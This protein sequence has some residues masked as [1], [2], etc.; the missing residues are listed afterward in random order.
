[1]YTLLID[2]SEKQKQGGLRTVRDLKE[3]FC[4][5]D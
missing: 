3:I 2:R 4:Q 1:M 5:I